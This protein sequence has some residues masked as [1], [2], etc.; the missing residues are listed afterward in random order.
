[1]KKLLLLFMT[2]F[3]ISFASA[4]PT[5]LGNWTF[6][7]GDGNSSTIYQ[8]N[9]TP[10]NTVT[11]AEDAINITDGNL[12]VSQGKYT[13]DMTNFTICAWVKTGKSGFAGVVDFPNI[14]YIRK[15]A[16][17]I[18]YMEMY[19]GT[20][21]PVVYGSN[22]SNDAWYHFCARR[23]NGLSNLSMFIGG[24]HVSSVGD[25]TTTLSVAQ[26]MA[27]GST[28]L[29]TD[30]LGGLLDELRIYN[31][32]VTDADINAIYSAGRTIGASVAVEL[33]SPIDNDVTS[34]VGLNFTSNNTPTSC[35]LTNATFLV[36][37]SSG[38]IF[39]ETTTTTFAS[40]NSTTMEIDAFTLGSYTWNVLV[41]GNNASTT[42]CNVADANYTLQVGASIDN[43][44]WEDHV[45]ETARELF[46]INVTLIANATIYDAELVYNGTA[47]D[48]TPTSISGDQYEI[49]AII[50][51]PEAN[52][53][54]DVKNFFWTFIYPLGGGEFAYQNTS[55]YTQN[56]SEISLDDCSSNTDIFLNFTYYNEENDTRVPDGSFDGTFEYWLGGGTE[57]RNYSVS[58]ATT[59]ETNICLSP[60]NL[61]YY[62]DA[63]IQY[64]KSTF[65]KRSYYLINASITN[66]TQDIGLYLLKSGASTSFIIEVLDGNQI[67][68]D[69]AYVFI[70]RYYPGTG[71]YQTVEMARTDEGGTTVGHF[72]AET[73]DYRAIIQKDGV[74]LFQSERQ[75]IYCGDTPCTVTFQTEAAAGTVW[76]DFGNVTNLVWTLD[77]DEDT[78]I[79]EYT[80]VDTSGTTNYGKLLV[81]Q[82]RGDSRVYICNV[83][84]TSAASTLTCNITGQNGTVYAAAI[85]SRSP[86]ILVYL[87]NVVVGTLKDVFGNEG[88]FLSSLIIL[89]VGLVG[90]WNPAV[91][92]MLVIAA[93]I[94]VN[95]MGLASFGGIAIGGIVVLG[96]LLIWLL[97]T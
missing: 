95:F 16:D 37:N 11:W 72:E 12:N 28:Y 92:V 82:D 44:S 85:I 78:N 14:F 63:Q 52:A 20:N 19:D 51:I 94:F 91:G 83:S 43:S 29:H 4:L 70:Q 89:T 49:R 35:N 68:I 65:V 56:I 80:Y 61:T 41:C 59:N 58:V 57:R 9:T 64:E 10:I 96:I 32:S 73:E 74:V 66:I 54:A 8:Q 31:G 27:I 3:L 42:V 2:L 86:E 7:D 1:M 25:N 15:N 79:W 50:D 93:V 21:N 48:A 33:S 81:Y 36:W 39:N 75:R 76:S 67:P 47:Y 45:Y 18:I 38:Q 97:R 84:A 77:F 46:Q 30:R 13:F 23:D 40:D 62:T 24:V 69:Q 34:D 87:Q 17:G 71:V 26:D 5:H 53:T 6:E 22:V 55:D 88:L 90:V 60:A